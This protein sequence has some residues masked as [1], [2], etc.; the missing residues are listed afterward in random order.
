MYKL[1]KVYRSLEFAEG[2]VVAGKFSLFSW[3]D[4]GLLS[5]FFLSLLVRT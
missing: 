1:R 2:G 3:D 4:P 5:F